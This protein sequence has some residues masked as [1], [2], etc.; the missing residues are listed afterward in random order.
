MDWSDTLEAAA[1]SGDEDRLVGAL[2]IVKSQGSDEVDDVVRILRKTHSPRVRNAAAIALADMHPPNAAN[3]L[4]EVLSKPETKNSRGTLLY[5][6][7]EV[8]GKA[9]LNLLADIILFDTYEARQE[10]LRFIASGNIKATQPELSK[11]LRIFESSSPKDDEQAAAIS[12][13]ISTLKEFRGVAPSDVIQRHTALGKGTGSSVV[14]FAQLGEPVAGLT[15]LPRKTVE[16]VLKQ[17]AVLLARHLQKGQR[18]RIGGLEVLPP[19]SA[20]ARTKK[21]TVKLKKSSK[22]ISGKKKKRRASK[23]LRESI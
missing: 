14:S 7:E 1:A 17:F 18:V 6:L 8:S 11:V 13:A 19:R 3:V 20:V 23:D 4:I 12:E 9:P 2:R 21:S 10:A 16:A 22:S 15:N 5:A